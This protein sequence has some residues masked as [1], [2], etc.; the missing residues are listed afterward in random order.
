[1]KSI[2]IIFISLLVLSCAARAADPVGSF[3]QELIA[4]RAGEV[5]FVPNDERAAI[6]KGGYLYRFELDLDGDGEMEVFIATSLDVERKG[7]LW[8]IFKK[9]TADDYHKLSGSCFLG[10]ELRMK[11]ENGIRKYSFYVP[12]KE[13]EGG[14]YFGYFWLDAAGE[15]HEETHVLTDVE[16]ATKDGSDA[17]TL[18]AD[19]KPDDEK[20]A[21]KLNLGNSVALTIKKVL[22]A[23][24]SQNA[25]APWRDVK[26]D[27]SLAQQYRD[28]AD[29]SDIAS[30]ANWQPP[31]SPR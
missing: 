18:G 23:K 1:M 7:E 22:L 11:V 20:I 31:I 2:K 27:L 8:S 26:A 17:D 24:Y 21:E 25:A 4:K 19:G 15:W 6:P 28:P 5:W 3:A 13:Q 14:N 9:N 10:S 29:A 12:Q 30:V 16:Q